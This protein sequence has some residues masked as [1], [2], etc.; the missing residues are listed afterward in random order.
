MTPDL[1]FQG[2]SAENKALQGMDYYTQE[3]P[4]SSSKPEFIRICELKIQHLYDVLTPHAVSRWCF[5]VFLVFFYILRIIITQGFHVVT[6]VMGIFLLNRLIDFLS[7]K[8]VPETSTDEVLPTKSSEEF[9]PF[10]RRLPELKFWNSCT[11][12]LFISI[13]CTY[14]SFLDIPVFWPILVMYFFMLFYVTMKRQISHMIKYRYLPFT[15]GKPRHQSNG[16]RF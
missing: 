9:R 7:P 16:M 11:I 5:T 1:S 13:I 8:I 10:L 14:L 4:S 2:H 15:Y 6:Y 12:C 3:V